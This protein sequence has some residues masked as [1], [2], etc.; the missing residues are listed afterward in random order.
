MSV[1]KNL[2]TPEINCFSSWSF[3]PPSRQ[4]RDSFPF[5]SQSS[6]AQIYIPHFHVTCI[7]HPTRLDFNTNISSNTHFTLSKL[8]REL[9]RNCYGNGSYTFLSAQHKTYIT[10]YTTF[11]S[12]RSRV[13]VHDNQANRFSIRMKH[14]RYLNSRAAFPYSKATNPAPGFF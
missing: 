4:S 10:R 3:H 9:S 6:I 2:G 5:H 7:N 8:T 13:T 1:Y 14:P 12:Y 11:Q